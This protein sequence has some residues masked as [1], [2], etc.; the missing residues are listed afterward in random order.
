MT[1]LN[2]AKAPNIDLSLISQAKELK[3][4]ILFTILLLFVYRFGS[5]IPLPGIDPIALQE[6]AKTNSE[7]ILGV[8]NML[9]GG[10]L[11][12]MSI[13][14]LGI[15]PYITSSIIMQLFTI[16]FKSLG[17]L[18]KDGEAG[19]KKINQ[20]TRYLT[21]FLALF[22]GFGIAVGLESIATNSGQIV[23]DPGL[24]F[25]IAAISNLVGGTMFLMWLGDQIT[26]RGIGNGISLIIFSGIVAGIPSSIANLLQLS[27]TGALSEFTLLLVFLFVIALIGLIVFVERSHRKIIVQYPKRQ[28]GNKLYAG[29]TSHIPLKLN[30]SGV[31][32]PIFASTL[33]LF[34]LTI[35]NFSKTQENFQWLDSVVLYLSHGK[36]LYILLYIALITFFSFFYTAVIFNADETAENLKKYGGLI[37]GR[38]PGKNTAEFLD[39]ILTRITVLGSA[40]LSIVCVMPEVFVAHFSV[41]FYLGGTSILIV[42]NV[43]IDTVSQIQTHLFAHQYEGLMK[44]AKLR[45]K[46]S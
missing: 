28:V 2:K 46:K 32:P 14:A 18:K 13:F 38:R 39:Y 6:L 41:P 12:R 45:E 35:A 20:L 27:K 40:Y 30:T 19:R 34:P 1:I 42:V 11:G 29:E 24:F 9:S 31:I 17:D 3:S 36:P 33:L 26:S 4:K 8:F 5:Y 23:V 7:G 21:V 44:K 25:R 43:I 16:V 22:Q 15:T 37:P 10:S